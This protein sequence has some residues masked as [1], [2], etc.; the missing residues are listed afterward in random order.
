MENFIEVMEKRYASKS[1]DV[2]KKISKDDLKQI[3]EF[4]RLSPS[5]FGLEHWKFLAISNQELKDKLVPVCFGQSQVS[6]CSDLIVILAKVKQFDDDNS[7]VEDIF[8]SRMP[9]EVVD[10]IL[11]MTKGFI[12]QFKNKRELIDWSKKQ[13]YI[14]AANMMT[15]AK[16]LG[17]DSCPMEGFNEDELLKV[18]DINPEEY[19]IA[20]VIPFGYAN[21]TQREKTRLPFE[22]VVEFIE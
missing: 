14:A 12:S 13:C 21:D 17:I 22:E 7:Y 10:K 5:S 11:P 2:E 3:L 16:T 1:F 6:S 8:K 15:G 19:K 20:M 9:K 4:G 18:L